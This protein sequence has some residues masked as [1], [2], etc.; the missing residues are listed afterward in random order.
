MSSIQKLIRPELADFEAY[1]FIRSQAEEEHIWLNANELPWNNHADS[2]IRINRY[3]QQKNQSLIEKISKIY[4]VAA[5]ELVFFPGSDA[6]ID[7][8]VRLFCR[9][10]QDAILICP[11]TFGIYR[12]AA[13]IQ[14]AQVVEVPLLVAEDFQLDVSGIKQ[15]WTPEVKMIF[16]C[17][18]NNPTGN[19]LREEDLLELC[20]TYAGKSIVVIDEAYIEFSGMKSM[21][22]QLKH[23]SNLVILRTFSKAYGLAGARFGVLLAQAALI[24]R[25]TAIMLPCL[26]SNL[27]LNVVEQALT[28][29][30]LRL[31]LEQID[32]IRREREY[33]TQKFKTLPCI[34]K[35]WPSGAN[36]LLLQARNAVEVIEACKAAGVILRAPETHA[37]LPECV[38]ISIG[39]PEENAQVLKILT[40]LG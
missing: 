29:E 38:R 30:H 6:A 24:K 9:A 12:F 16:L 15:A 20:A 10:Q 34:K 17:S 8:L 28:P 23:Y 32:C 25:L 33:L 22:Q 11:P 2:S 4:Q 35:V 14:G 40:A 3:P 19:I 5:Q 21:T 39:T 7:L 13:E 18:P 37:Y 31:S 36:F 1:N 27:T 26:V